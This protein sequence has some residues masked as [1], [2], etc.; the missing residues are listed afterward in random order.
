MNSFR[1]VKL[2]LEVEIERQR[3][4]LEAGKQIV[5]ETR[6]WDEDKKATFSMRSKEEASDYRYFPEPDL[7]PFKIDKA[8]IEEVRNNLPELPG[9]KFERFKDQFN[10]S[11]PDAQ[12]LV[13]DYD[14]SKFF[15][16]CCRIASIPK[17]IVNWIKGPL[18]F[19]INARNK[20]LS[21][22]ELSPK[23]FVSL[24]ELTE[25]GTL[26]NLSA[27]AV[28]TEMLDKRIGPEQIIKEDNLAQV[29][30]NESLGAL[31]EEA[32]TEN[33][34]S[35]DSYLAGKENALMFLVGQVMKKSKGKANPK[36]VKELLEEKLKEKK[37]A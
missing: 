30:D 8:K 14:F 4:I 19:E 13:M 31:I 7:V 25:D 33:K 16:D 29:S 15:E 12:F 2:A 9:K 10:L 18:S 22:L 23:D 36:R 6:L 35:V 3:E 27:K 5:Q 11:V 21:E 34:N 28:L 20:S 1:A 26:S 17:A 37:N 32:L 24:I